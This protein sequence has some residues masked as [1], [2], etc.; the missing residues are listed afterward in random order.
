MSRYGQENWF[1]HQEDFINAF[2]AYA[3]L[4]WTAANTEVIHVD[5]GVP[6]GS[7][8]AVWRQVFGNPLFH[9]NPE[10]GHVRNIR[11]VV[12]QHKGRL[13]LRSAAFSI[14]GGLSIFSRAIAGPSS[15]GS[16]SI[17]QGYAQFVLHRFGVKAS[18]KG[19]TT[20][21]LS[22]AILSRKHYN[23]RIIS[24]II[25]NEGDLM[26]AIHNKLC[27]STTAESVQ[28]QDAA[29]KARLECHGIVITLHEFTDVPIS[30]QLRVIHASD[31]LIG[32]HGAG[33][34]HLL[35]LPDWAGLLELVHPERAGNY[36]FHNMAKLRGIHYDTFH[37]QD[38]IRNI[39]EVATHVSA[40]VENVRQTKLTFSSSLFR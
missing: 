36:H 35:F 4:N 32:A 19:N 33:L 6:Q 23:N 21:P 11:D 15:C 39:E 34:T 40:L 22:V 24:R 18:V 5:S 13:C 25:S 27:G 7:F 29:I 2:Q 37:I 1:H 38:P 12:H 16:S 9:P 8:H 26:R 31:V 28:L 30:D 20:D 14:H 3:V 10:D 17:V